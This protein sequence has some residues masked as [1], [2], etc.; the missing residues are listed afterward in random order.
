MPE[1]LIYPQVSPKADVMPAKQ[2]LYGHRPAGLCEEPEPS[3][4]R[5]VLSLTGPREAGTQEG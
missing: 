5:A 3:R 4:W 1:N 2:R